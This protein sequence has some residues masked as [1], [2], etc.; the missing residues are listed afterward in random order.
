VYKSSSKKFLPLAVAFIHI[1]RSV[2]C[3]AFTQPGE[4]ENQRFWDAIAR[5]TV[6][7]CKK[8]SVKLVF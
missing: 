8:N 2:F 3:F 7:Y 6:S 4:A 5:K 1:Y